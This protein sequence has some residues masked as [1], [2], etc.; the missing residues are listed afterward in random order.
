M[1]IWKKKKKKKNEIA[2]SL[3]HRK[4]TRKAKVYPKLHKSKKY[5]TE[6]MSRPLKAVLHSNKDR[7]ICFN[8]MIEHSSPSKILLFRSR[9]IFCII[10]C[11]ITPQMYAILCRPTPLSQQASN[12]TTCLGITQQ[13]P[14]KFNTKDHKSEAKGQWMSRWS[15][16]SQSFLQIQHLLT[17]QFFLFLKLSKARI[18]PFV[19]IQVKKLP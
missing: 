16:N 4:C 12:S 9:Y 10:N 14:C 11:R 7:K 15:T 6:G 17:P 1:K 8:S 3:V 5:K 19:A 18:L 2:N 13:I